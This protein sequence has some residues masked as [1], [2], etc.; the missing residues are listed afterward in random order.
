MTSAPIL[1]L[2]DFHKPFAMETG[3]CSRSIGAILLQGGRPITYFSK[4]LA[5]KN[6]GLSTYEKEYLAILAAVD[7]WRHYLMG[8]HFIIQTD[9]ESL[10][11]L[12]D[13]KITT[14]LQPKGLTKPLRLDYDIKYK[15]ENENNVVNALSRRDEK[16]LTLVTISSAE[17]TWMHEVALSYENDQK[18]L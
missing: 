13:K 16:S 14:V 18:A 9:H 5:P 6:W 7:R 8:G 2:A 11:F 15:N 10:K 3:A 1:A 17:P 4:T 12:L